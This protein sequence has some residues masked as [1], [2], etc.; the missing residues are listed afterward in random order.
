MTEEQIPH[1]NEIKE[2]VNKKRKNMKIEEEERVLPPSETPLPPLKKY[3]R[4]PKVEPIKKDIKEETIEEVLKE[5]IKEKELIKEEK[6]EEVI[7]YDNNHELKELLLEINKKLENLSIKKER[8]KVIKPKEINKTL[9]LSIDNKEI[10]NIIEKDNKVS[11][12]IIKDE[13]LQAF[14]NGFLKR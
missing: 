5:P 3:I 4:K 2:I 14:I 13:K 11:D 7:K 6:I 9:D 1:I 8:K 12:N 10:E